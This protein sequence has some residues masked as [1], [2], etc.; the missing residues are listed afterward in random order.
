MYWLWYYFEHITWLFWECNRW[1]YPHGHGITCPFV[2]MVIMVWFDLEIG[3]QQWTSLCK[4]NK[5]VSVLYMY[6]AI[7]YQWLFQL[8]N[9]KNWTRIC[10]ASFLNGL[11]SRAL[12]SSLQ[13]SSPE[14]ARL[15]FVTNGRHQVGTLSATCTSSCL[16]RGTTCQCICASCSREC[17]ELLRA[18]LQGMFGGICVLSM[19]C[20]YLLDRWT[21]LAM[22]SS[23]LDISKN[24]TG[25]V[26]LSE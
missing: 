19:E 26:A 9:D 11:L 13:G 12:D 14:A 24:I 5:L 20:M 10:S 17:Y 4:V 1:F 3:M 6:M 16:L 8:T 15:S 22:L 21:G 18:E 23:T 25:L 2:I 7:T